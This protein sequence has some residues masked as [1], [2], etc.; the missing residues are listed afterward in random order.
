MDSTELKKRTK[1][2]A[3]RCV[4]LA[5]SLPRTSLGR[6]VEKQL[7]RCGTSVASNY[8]ATLMAQTKAGFISKISIVIEEADESEFWLEFI[9]DEKLLE[10]EKGLPLLNEAHELTSIFIA[11][12]KTAQRRI[13]DGRL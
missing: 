12:R 4:K 8:R 2:F 7:V 6:H 9:I 10:R 3:H 5:A 1:E 13:N 11:S